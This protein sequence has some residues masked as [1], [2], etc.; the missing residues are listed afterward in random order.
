M[1]SEASFI[2]AVHQLPLWP[3][4]WQVF[5]LSLSSVPFCLSHSPV[6]EGGV[7]L[8][9]RLTALLWSVLLTDSS[10]CLLYLCLCGLIIHSVF[11]FRGHRYL[12][13]R[14]IC[15]PLFSELSVSLVVKHYCSLW[16]F[17]FGAILLCFLMHQ[18]FLSALLLSF[19]A[20]FRWL[21]FRH[22]S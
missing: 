12:F 7:G 15:I 5:G 19:A 4:S 16:L 17:F 22:C 18:T 10:E 8:L 9:I 20:S 6:L 13:S 11:D 2:F 3:L 14:Y 21:N 1:F